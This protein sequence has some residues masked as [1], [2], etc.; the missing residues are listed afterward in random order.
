MTFTSPAKRI[1]LVLNE[2]VRVST[3]FLPYAFFCLTKTSVLAVTQAAEN[4]MSTIRL[5][6]YDGSKFYKKVFLIMT[7]HFMTVTKC[8]FYC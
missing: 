3:D 2:Y 4:P 6:C 7:R 1:Q 8:F 5:N